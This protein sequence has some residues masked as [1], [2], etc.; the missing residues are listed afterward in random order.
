MSSLLPFSW[1]TGTSDK[2]EKTQDPF[3]ALRQEIDRVFEDF[4]RWPMM[5]LSKFT[6]ATPKLNVSE[7]DQALEVEAELPGMDEKDVEVIF[8]DNVLTL[9]G[10]KKSEREEKKKD[11]HVME[12]S[13]GAFSRSIPL[14]FDADPGS[15][16][17]EFD[18]GV[19]RLTIPKPKDLV[20][21]TVKIDIQKK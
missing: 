12:R 7:T 21:K 9:R 20:T 19:L 13:Y 11:F 6:T 18:K 8:R 17:A 1:M 10:E 15:I 4:G 16:K 2:G 14:P 3:G 5:S